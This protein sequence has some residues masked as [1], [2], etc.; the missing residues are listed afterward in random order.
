MNIQ[1]VSNPINPHLERRRR[2]EKEDENARKE[3]RRTSTSRSS[4]SIVVG[5]TSLSSS[6]SID[7]DDDERE[8]TTVW[9]KRETLFLETFTRAVSL[10]LSLSLSQKECLDEES[11]KGEETKHRSVFFCLAGASLTHLS[12]FFLRVF[13]SSSFC[14]VFLCLVEREKTLFVAPTRQKALHFFLFRCV[15]LC[16]DDGTNHPGGGGPEAARDIDEKKTRQSTTRSLPLL[17][18]FFERNRALIRPKMFAHKTTTTSSSSGAFT[19]HVQKGVAAVRRVLE[20]KTSRSPHVK[21]HRSM[22]I[23]NM[24]T[25]PP[26]NSAVSDIRVEK[27]EVKP[28]CVVELSVV[29]PMD[30]LAISYEN[31]IDEATAQAN[32]PGFEAPKKKDGSRKKKDTKKPPMNMLLNAVGKD[33]FLLLCIEDAL[34]STMPQAM[35][36]VAKEAI[37]DSETITTTP[38]Q[39]VEAFGGPECTPSKEMEYTVK[40]CIQPTVQWTKDIDNLEATYVSPGNDET[41][42]RDTE[43]MFQNRLRDMATM[44]VVEDRGLEQGDV[45][46]IDINAM[47]TSGNSLPGI[48]TK[49]FRLDT[50]ETDLK[51]P[52]LM[53]EIVGIKVGEEK[54]FNLTF[55][56]DWS[57]KSVAGKTAMFT[58]K[59]NELFSREMPELSD[60]IAD[61]IFA[62][63][64][65]V[66]EAKAQILEAQ[67]MS[68]EVEEA[69]LKDQALLDAL[70]AAC[71]CEI[72]ESMLKEQSENMFGEHLTE[73]QMEGKM[74][75]KAIQSLASEEN[76]NKF[77]EE[78]KD[79]IELICKRTIACETLFT[80]KNM[81]IT[82]G[83][84][85]DE[86]KRQVKDFEA[87]GI[88]YEEDRMIQNARG[89][90]EAAK[91]MQWLKDNVKLTELPPLERPA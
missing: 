35:Q 27:S 83:E 22:T 14:L 56:E 84:L 15:I 4:D 8:T 43:T 60:D 44:R 73:M 72:P 47:D 9:R 65:T 40:M 37:Q 26:A 90:V 12:F 86:L 52:G 1:S 25:T 10:S 41:D 87:Q 85:S 45:A 39:M 70:A 32:I 20:K 46:V 91:T 18:T 34:T 51:L 42:K 16:S 62:G 17:F 38:R 7:D 58:V 63:S 54:D 3:E 49:G 64:K 67:K 81:V 57:I 55:P 30:V 71:S 61:D 23:T 11:T 5:G 2:E 59:V 24:A 31:A 79:E 78:R 69:M 19:P 80:E 36:F 29:V 76:M 13:L 50:E 66:E 21:P 68:R 74:S 88:E 28:G 33:Q 53:E 48:E 89:A 75:M 6:F 82:Q 77:V